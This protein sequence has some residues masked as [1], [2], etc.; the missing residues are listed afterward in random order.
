MNT[1][2]WDLSLS[3]D[4]VARQL[5]AKTIEVLFRLK[6]ITVEIAVLCTLNDW[7]MVSSAFIYLR[8]LMIFFFNMYRV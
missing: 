1:T 3:S 6:P 5:N 4:F 2:L 7:W 8:L